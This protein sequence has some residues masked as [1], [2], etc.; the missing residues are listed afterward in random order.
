MNRTEKFKEFANALGS[1]LH[2]NRTMFFELDDS[3]FTG[4]IGDQGELIL[5][6]YPS[7]DNY[8]S[9]EKGKCLGY[10]SAN[11]L[12]AALAH[13]L[14]SHEDLSSFRCLR[15]DAIP[16]KEGIKSILNSKDTNEPT[17]NSPNP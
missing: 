14:E 6:Q 7:M 2:N 5:T 3:F 1:D 17:F 8:L 10:F 13:G 16:K 11:T 9:N 4:A 12:S 15:A